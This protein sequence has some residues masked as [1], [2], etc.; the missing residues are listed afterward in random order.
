MKNILV[1]SSFYKPHIGGVEKYIENFYKRLPNHKVTIITSKYDKSL[2]SED[3]D[4]NLNIVRIDSIQIIRDKYYIPTLKGLKKMKKLINS[5]NSNKTEIH[6]HTRFY[7][8]NVIATYF[9]KKYKLKHY[10]FEHGSSFVKDGPFYVRIFAYIFDKTFAKYILKNSKLIFP[11]SESV[12]NFLNKNY[13]NIKLGPTM[14]NSYDF[15]N[16]KIQNKKKPKL[17]KLLFV[18]RI[19][20]SKGIYE[21]VD[22]CKFLS[23]DNIK[24]S[25]TIIGDGSEREN[26]EKYIKK[27]NIKN[28]VLKGQLPY[29][30]TQKE[31]SKYDIFVNPSYTEGLP[32]TVLE[33]LANNLIVIATDA[34]G[35]REIIPENKLIKLNE[36]SP[37]IIAEYIISSWNNWDKEQENFKKIFINAKNKFDWKKNINKYY[38]ATNCT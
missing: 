5:S 4:E 31:Y 14:Y 21:L 38:S 37:E 19:I 2:K 17:L 25:L 11:I 12:R 24:Y 9:A 7:F 22:S 16:I 26:L 32:T 35:T 34:G 30:D 6:T 20:K 3:K 27:N 10:H 36:L 15:K 28:I 13:K 23:K 1:F 29:E 8:T 33:A 18:G